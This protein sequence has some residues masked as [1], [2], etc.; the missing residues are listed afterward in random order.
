MKL[1]LLLA[2]TLLL[3]PL[4]GQ[5]DISAEALDVTFLV[6]ADTHYGL[7]QWGDNE[8]LNK[9]AID[10]MNNLEGTA[11]PAVAGGSPIEEIRGVLVP[12]DLTDSGTS[13]NLYGYWFFG[14][15]DGFVDDYGINGNGRLQYEVYEGYGNHDIHDPATGVVLSEIASRNQV[16][17]GVTNISANG[18]HYS[19]D[20]GHAH[21]VNLN[22][23][24]GGAGD[25]EDSLGFL[26]QDL[27]SQVGDSG[28]PVILYHHYGFDPFST[29]WWTYEERLAYKAALAGYNV[30][31]IFS[32]HNHA[33]QHRK[34]NGIHAFNAPRAKDQRFLAVRLTPRRLVVAVRNGDAWSST[35]IVKL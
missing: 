8:S 6:A 17:T 14:H 22:V 23:Y 18:L 9:A 3:T 27:Q 1:S 26:V 21:F 10:R 33:A 34:W 7:D 31:A 15:I 13:S 19:F 24:P 5:N 35:W 30:V 28:R 4:G 29:S 16:R 32:G 11:W 25:A 12:G 2:A 20:W